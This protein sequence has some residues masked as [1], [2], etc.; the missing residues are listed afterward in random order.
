MAAIY[1]DMED[2]LKRVMNNKKLYA[3]LLSK[4]KSNTDLQTLTAAVAAGDY[5][6]AEI[7][8]H[9]IKGIAG[10]LSLT[11]LFKQSQE[12]DMK[13]KTKLKKPDEMA[14]TLETIEPLLT[15]F[16]QTLISIDKVLADYA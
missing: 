1:I 4:F 14:I 6:K 10:N 7:E 3:H 16:E 8:A 15:C 5:E 13:F 11:E 2:G 12:L 9:T